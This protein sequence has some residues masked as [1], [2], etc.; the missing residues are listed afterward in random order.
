MTS[1]KRCD[2]KMCERVRKIVEKFHEPLLEAGVTFSLL[3]AHA[4]QDETGVPLGPA[5]R[6]GG[7][8]AY[9]VASITKLRDRAQGI[10]D[11]QIVFDGDRWPNIER[12]VQDALI[13]HELQHFEVKEDNTD[14]CGRPRLRLRKHDFQFGW[15]TSIAE[16][17]GVA[18]IE[19][20][21]MKQM[22]ESTGQLFFP[23][24]DPGVHFDLARGVRLLD[25]LRKRVP[26][27]DEARPQ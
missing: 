18:A 19:T 15:F 9:A 27:G 16:R 4:E 13:D 12:K 21:Q 5:L 20:L 24:L 11:A 26:S 14:A 2:A 23:W 8:L 7:Y 1:Y 17:H 3:F 22:V 6:H 25:E 10:A